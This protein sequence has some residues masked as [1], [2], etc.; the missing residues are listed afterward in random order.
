[1]NYA[2]EILKEQKDGL[3]WVVNS[4]KGSDKSK[5]NL[6]DVTQALQLLQTGVSSSVCLDTE[7]QIKLGEL[8]QQVES[9]HCYL[10]KNKLRNKMSA[11]CILLDIDTFW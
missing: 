6:A 3:E 1:M 4:L 7:L 8:M 2:I 11:I 9:S 5:Q 10:E